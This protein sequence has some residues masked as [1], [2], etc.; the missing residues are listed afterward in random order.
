MVA[1]R[2]KVDEPVNRRRPHRRVVATQKLG[3]ASLERLRPVVGLFGLGVDH[4]SL[5]AGDEGG[6]DD[7]DNLALEHVERDHGR[8]KLGSR[9]ADGRE[10]EVQRVEALG[11]QQADGGA[12]GFHRALFGDVRRDEEYAGGIFEHV[13]EVRL[14]GGVEGRVGL[15]ERRFERLARGGVST[16]SEREL[17]VAR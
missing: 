2:E 9:V 1:A 6:R 3:R 5:A 7:R 12:L 14:V 8:T 17:L 13:D 15:L 4:A 10:G 16:F 11:L